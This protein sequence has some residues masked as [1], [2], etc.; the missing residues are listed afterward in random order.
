MYTTVCGF[1]NLGQKV[2]EETRLENA[3]I[4][5]QGRIMVIRRCI[6]LAELNIFSSAARQTGFAMCCDELISNFVTCGLSPEEVA[7]SAGKMPEGSILR[8]KLSDLAEI[9]RLTEE[10]LCETGQMLS[11]AC[12]T[13]C[14]NILTSKL[15]DAHIYIDGIENPGDQT[16]RMIQALIK[17]A[18]S[19]TVALRCDTEENKATS[20]FLRENEIYARL[21]AAVSEVG[22]SFTVRRMQRDGVYDSKVLEHIEKE[23]FK[24]P[25]RKFS[26]DSSCVELICAKDITTEVDALTCAVLSRVKKGARFRNIAVVAANPAKYDVL[27]KQKFAKAGIPVFCDS[28]LRLSGTSAA[29][30]INSALRC[31][32]SRFRARDVITLM[33]TALTGLT[34]DECETLENYILAYD[35]SGSGLMQPFTVGD[36]PE[37][38]EDSRCCLMQPLM[39]LRQGMSRA[40]VGD[41][42]DALLCYIDELGIREK[43]AETVED[44]RQ[45]RHLV[46]AKQY[47]QV[48]ELI[49]ETLMQLKN[50]MG[51]SSMS[52]ER[53]AAVV[54]EGLNAD[55]IGIIPAGVDMVTYS[56]IENTMPTGVEYVFVVGATEGDFP[57]FRG[58]DGIIDDRELSEI[59]STGLGVWLSVQ[60]KREQ[61]NANI[62]T[63]LTCAFKGIYISYPENS[64]GEGGK[65]ASII[66]RLSGMLDK[67]FMHSSDALFP[68][69]FYDMDAVAKELRAFADTHELSQQ[70]AAKLAWYLNDSHYG[71][72]TEKLAQTVFFDPDPQPLQRDFAM[73]LYDAGFQ[74]NA[75]RLETF[76]ECPFSHFMKYGLRAKERREYREKVVDTGSFCHG[77]IDAFVR[78]VI[79]N[80]IPYEELT[81]QRC[82]D[83]VDMLAPRIAL[84]YNDG[85][86]NKNPRYRAKKDYITGIAK[87]TVTAIMRHM[88]KGDFVFKASE[89]T[90]GSGREDTFPALRIELEGGRT[91]LVS[92][93][94]DR[95]D[96]YEKKDEE[97]KNFR[98]IDY[99]LNGKSFDLGDL[100]EGIKMQLPL[101]LE[102][103]TQ[104]VS[105]SVGCGMF[106]MPVMKKTLKRE[107][108]EKNMLSELMKKFKLNGILL[109]DAEIV[110]ATDRDYSEKAHSLVVTDTRRINNK[111]ASFI[112]PK[113]KIAAIRAFAMKKARETAENIM[114]GRIDVKPYR[115]KKK[116]ACEYCL[117]KSVCMFDETLMNCT[118]REIREI[119]PDMFFDETV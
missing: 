57:P 80:N 70:S 117:Y 71:K 59:K 73:Q 107:D 95:I 20:V 118:Y 55:I 106:Y 12:D 102:A 39:K 86:F 60:S 74:G 81:E 112:L 5:E 104:A 79:E 37:T 105:G 89:V 75:T 83:I 111:Q 10:Y 28:R 22:E 65:P 7:F 93:K 43:L 13:I 51:D 35:L 110:L 2:L 108:A 113:E 99:K 36:I 53:F 41:K 15:C 78:Y 1:Y 101:Y 26:G 18:R 97:E 85:M 44:F 92:G 87:D 68:Y 116:T 58:D 98:V 45:K 84:E 42:T 24:L 114:S 91:F 11:A 40:S 14:E 63:L 62:Y 50:V 48:Y 94:I 90:F 49:C 76:N 3:F 109:S 31:I 100:Y 9:Y 33:K 96:G 25:C 103:V 32:C 47:E 88:Q 8:E 72:E 52:N 64:A 27:I 23:L 17:R 56:G 115:K 67:P 46:Q 61:D 66:N 119:D 6:E 16:Y 69:S 4:T 77:I 82:H 54:E 29:V 38:A 19:V 21:R 34:R 30:L